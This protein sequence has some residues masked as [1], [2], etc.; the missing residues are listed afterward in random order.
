MAVCRGCACRALNLDSL[1]LQ[2]E[3]EVPAEDDDEVLA[4]DGEEEGEDEEL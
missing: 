3:L 1:E 2:P 4:E